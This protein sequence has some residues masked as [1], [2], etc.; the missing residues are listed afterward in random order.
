MI[1]VRDRCWPMRISAPRAT[2][3]PS[4]A[5]RPPASTRPPHTAVASR[6]SVCTPTAADNTPVSAAWPSDAA[7]RDHDHREPA[8]RARPGSGFASATIASTTAPANATLHAKPVCVCISITGIAANAPPVPARSSSRPRRRA[9]RDPR[10]PAPAR[11]ATSECCAR[12]R[13]GMRRRDDRTRTV[14]AEPCLEQRR[15][16][17]HRERRVHQRRERDLTDPQAVELHRAHPPDSGR[18]TRWQQRDG[19]REEGNGTVENVI[20][21]SGNGRN[22]WTCGG[23][24]ARATSVRSSMVKTHAGSHRHVAMRVKLSQVAN[25]QEPMSFAK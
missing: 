25:G 9:S 1:D 5:A 20:D 16:D 4:A 11:A 14:L 15:A 18:P 3:D 2:D 21:E 6:C 19:Q 22:D 23:G 17:R 24:G 13:A 10:A 12:S 7:G 8:P